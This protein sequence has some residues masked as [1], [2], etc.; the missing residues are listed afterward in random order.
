M[1]KYEYLTF[2]QKKEDIEVLPR[3]GCTSYPIDDRRFIGFGGIYDNEEDFL[4][5]GMTIHYF[6]VEDEEK[7]TYFRIITKP[8]FSSNL[9]VL[10]SLPKRMN[11]NLE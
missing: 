8:K 10:P 6:E 9:G 1:Y 2:R 7:G 3:I 5:V 11:Y 4:R